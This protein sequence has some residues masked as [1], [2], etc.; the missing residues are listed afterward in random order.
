M[1]LIKPIFWVIIL[2]SSLAFYSCEK[3]S[4]C[5]CQLYESCRD[6]AVC[7]DGSTSTSTGQGT[8]SSHGGVDY[9]TCK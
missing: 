8:C 1:K 6:G 7:Q 9:W 3:E 5:D 2:L 4:N